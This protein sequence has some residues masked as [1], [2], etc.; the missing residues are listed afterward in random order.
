MEE[1][2][3]AVRLLF[4]LLPWEDSQQ[5]PLSSLWDCS[6][7]RPWPG[8]GCGGAWGC[9]HF[10]GKCSHPPHCSDPR[11]SSGKGKTQTSTGV[12]RT[13]GCFSSGSHSFISPGHNCLFWPA[14]PMVWAGDKWASASCSHCGHSTHCCCCS[15]GGGPR[16]VFSVPLHQRRQF[17]LTWVP[18]LI[19]TLSRYTT[20]EW[21]WPKV[22][23]EV[24]TLAA[25]AVLCQTGTGCWYLRVLDMIVFLCF[26]TIGQSN[27]FALRIS[28]YG[29]IV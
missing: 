24:V 27:V 18:L 1:A 13:W 16:P 21:L 23:P 14:G 10:G 4:W 8:E 26:T 15:W 3:F 2:S 12:S 9:L 11:H 7:L 22:L 20:F 29:E 28:S 6:A 25:Q 19:V 5:V 17:C